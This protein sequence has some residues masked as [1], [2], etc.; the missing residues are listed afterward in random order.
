MMRFTGLL[1]VLLVASMPGMKATAGDATDP[2]RYEWSMEHPGLRTG[3]PTDWQFGGPW[4]HMAR[5]AKNEAASGERSLLI[6]DDDARSYAFWASKR[7]NLR[8]GVE[9]VTWSFAIKPQQLRGDWKVVLCFYN[10]TASLGFRPVKRRIDANL[11]LEKDKLAVTWAAET[12]KKRTSE[13]R[14]E[15]SLNQAGPNGF[16][17]LARLIAV[18]DWA[19][20]FRI[21]FVSSW[22][23]SATGKVWLDDVSVH[24]DDTATSGK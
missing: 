1:T 2:V 11:A 14:T 20:S 7:K 8:S 6:H 19:K 9:Q 22:Q 12:E 24:E 21:A 23:P 4:P 3:C 18:P 5:W 13:D 17:T 16:V 15:V 10:N